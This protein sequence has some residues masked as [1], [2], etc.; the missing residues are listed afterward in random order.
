MLRA[1]MAPAFM[2]PS[3]ASPARWQRYALFNLLLLIALGAWLYL[4]NR[5]VQLADLPAEM[6]TGCVSYA[7]YYGKDQTPLRADT[8]ISPQQI[9]EDLALLSKQ[10]QCVRTYSVDQ[11][12][13]HVPEAAQRLGMKVLLGAW[14]GWVD[15]KNRQELNKAIALANRYQSTVSALIVG[16]EV[17]LRG[18]QALPAMQKYLNHAQESTSVPVTY[19]DVW[20]YWLRYPGL[21]PSVD[22]ITVHILPYWE[23][24]PQSIDNA[25]PHAQQVMNKLSVQFDKP[26]FVGETGWPSRGRQRGESVPSQVNQTRYLREFIS[27]AHQQGW[28]Y[29]LIEAIDQPWKRHLEGTVGGEWGLYDSALQPKFT[30]TGS[31]VE[32]ADG[33][34]PA[35]FAVSGLLLWCGIARRKAFAG[36][37]MLAMAS[38]GA[39]TGLATWVGVDYLHTVSRDLFEWLVLGSLGVLALSISLLLPLGAQAHTQARQYL[40]TALLLLLAAGAI[41]GCFLAFDGRYRDFPLFLFTLPALQLA[42]GARLLALPL[43]PAS[44]LYLFIHLLSITLAAACVLLD[45]LNDHAWAWAALVLLLATVSWPD[46]RSATL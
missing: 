41:T 13:E 34:W 45:P 31:V 29:N 35:I 30:R 9:D 19:A 42:L 15:S 27:T 16:N 23:D 39:L 32:R 14:I 24:H 4:H 6:Q 10:F 46:K 38:L 25:I 8:W 36:S 2:T 7:P 40:G 22:Y 37:A 17:L 12:L 26:L 44:R 18:E 28:R 43:R 5:P 1:L 33:V 11:G 21:A 20:E 3:S